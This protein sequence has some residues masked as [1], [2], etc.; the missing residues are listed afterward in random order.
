MLVPAA[1][2]A[3]TRLAALEEV[4]TAIASRGRATDVSTRAANC[5]V[6]AAN[7]SRKSGSWRGD[8]VLTAERL[9]VE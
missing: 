1:L 3:T 5:E 2:A 9:G 8:C 4:V 6:S 7:Q